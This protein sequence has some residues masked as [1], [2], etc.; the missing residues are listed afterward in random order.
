MISQHID[1]IKHFWIC[2][3]FEQHSQR[4]YPQRTIAIAGKFRKTPFHLVIFVLEESTLVLM[5]NIGFTI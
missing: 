5:K 3:F 4:S 2:L 1:S